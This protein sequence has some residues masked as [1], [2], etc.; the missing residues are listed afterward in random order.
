MAYSDYGAYIW[1]NGKNITDECADTYCNLINGKFILKEPLANSI[2]EKTIEG[3]AI[4]NLEKFC[5]CFYKTYNP[6][7]YYTNGK[8]KEIKIK[9]DYSYINAKE[10][11]SIRGYEL[12]E[13]GIFLF[14]E[15]DYKQD[16]YCVIVGNS[17]GNGFDNTPASK[18]VL[19]HLILFERE[20]GKKIYTIET[21]RGIDS[22]T[23]FNKLARLQEI[24]DKK[25][26]KKSYIKN[27]LKDFLKLKFKNLGWYIRNILQLKEEIKWLK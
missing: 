10:Q 27:F 1:K 15:I 17:I 11:L 7:L 20:D 4:I 3:H 21:K 5:I 18:Y 12:E 24:K 26:W 22:Y 6:V 8:S 19:K 13:N 2:S 23:V 25:E 14:Y 16:K 9:E